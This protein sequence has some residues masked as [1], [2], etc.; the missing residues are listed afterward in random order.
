[1]ATD[2]KPRHTI[3]YRICGPIS[4]L[5]LGYVLFGYYSGLV[6]SFPSWPS[7][8]HYAAAAA[9]ACLAFYLLLHLARAMHHARSL[10]RGRLAGWPRGYRGISGYSASAEWGSCSLRCCCSKVR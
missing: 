9:G 8:G 2:V 10:K 3:S 1:M 5:F 4:L 7:A 6:V